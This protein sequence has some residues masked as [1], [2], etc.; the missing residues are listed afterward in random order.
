MACGKD[1]RNPAALHV[2]LAQLAAS[3]RVSDT[4]YAHDGEATVARTKISHYGE[5]PSDPYGNDSVDAFFEHE[6]ERGWVYRGASL[7]S[8][9]V[10]SAWHWKSRVDDVRPLYDDEQAPED[11]W[12]GFTPPDERAQLPD[13][14][15]ENDEDDYW[16]QYGAGA[17][18]PE[19]QERDADADAEADTEAAP[20]E[21]E[22]LTP[23]M[24][25]LPTPDPA[26]TLSLLLSGLGAPS[27]SLDVDVDADDEPSP[28][29]T[30]ATPLPQSSTSTSTDST[31]L[32]Q[33]IRAKVR[34]QLVRAWSA[35][36]A[37]QDGEACGYEW[38][39]AARTVAD[40]PAWGSNNSSQLDA[41]ADAR[42]SVMQAR[43]EAAKDMHD[44]LG[45]NGSFFRLCEEAIRVHSPVMEEAARDEYEYDYE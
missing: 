41:W 26:A 5:Y 35:F 14:G 36:S 1:A 24:A 39:R 15:N 42:T 13:S 9:N 3:P 6:G 11:Y 38:L 27:L 10:G 22:P 23:P 29:A 20:S 25:T 37:G 32:T 18:V 44:V 7:G 8:A 34:S 43:I 45:E 31:I 16:A 40:A 4:E 17:S 2:A 21:P 28:F 33:K 19:T 12:A 30:A